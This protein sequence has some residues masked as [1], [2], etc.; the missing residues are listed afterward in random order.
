MRA[1]HTPNALPLSRSQWRALVAAAGRELGWGL[2]A[3]S[4]EVR[5]W[6]A[7]AAAIPDPGLRRDALRAQGSKRGHIDGAAMFWTLPRR[8][9]PVLLSTLV[10]Y[11]LLQD[12]LDSASEDSGSLGPERGAAL[13]AAL[14]DALDPARSPS[15]YLAHL[16]RCDD[17]GYIGALVDACRTGCRA[18]PSHAAVR[19]LLLREVDRAEVLLLNHE[20]RAAARR[21]ALRRWAEGH[22]G[23]AIELPWH[24]LTAAASGWITTHALL[25]VA[26]RPGATVS[27]AEAVHAAYFPWLALTLTLIDGYADLLEDAATGGHNYLSY[28]VDEAG[29]VD[30]L[31]ECIQRAAHA[32]RALPDGRRHAVLLACMVAL[33]LSKDSVRAP[34]RRTTTAEIAAAGGSLTELLLPVLRTWRVCNGQQR[35]T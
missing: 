1:A 8:R 26:A 20:P 10:Q 35:A 27:E 2:R 3:V 5:R 13:Y 17:G 25:A 11:E 34:E 21:A 14:G 22:F 23:A 18:L 32:V 7:R 6:Q 30:R 29:A 16:P 19:P 12:F 31:C 28:Y 4:R 33:Y 9:N 15:A 24:E